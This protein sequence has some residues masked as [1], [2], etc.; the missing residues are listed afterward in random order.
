MHD[1]LNPR[2]PR[3]TLVI[4]F[5]TTRRGKLGSFG[6]SFCTSRWIWSLEEL[7][8]GFNLYEL[9]CTLYST[10]IYIYN[11]IHIHIVIFIYLDTYTYSNIYIIWY[12]YIYIYIYIYMHKLYTL[13]WLVVWTIFYF[14]ILLGIVPTD[15]HIF[16]RGRYTTNQH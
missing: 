16:Q 4:H 3:R 2:S 13:F 1:F 15:F 10:Y 6:F 7:Y 5:S 14:P 12:I 11:L 8:P 9:M